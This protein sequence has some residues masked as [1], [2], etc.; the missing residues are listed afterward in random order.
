[1]TIQVPA[2]KVEKA[3]FESEEKSGKAEENS[4]GLTHLKY[5]TNI[6]KLINF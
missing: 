5:I 3:I 2:L 4:I 6:S 1:M